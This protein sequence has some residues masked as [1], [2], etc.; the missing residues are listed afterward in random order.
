MILALLFNLFIAELVQT[1]YVSKLCAI[2]TPYIIFDYII[3]SKGHQNRSILTADVRLVAFFLFFGA[4]VALTFFGLL[5]AFV[6]P[7]RTRLGLRTGSTTGSGSTDLST[8]L[9]TMLITGD[10]PTIVS[11]Y[12]AFK[13]LA[14]AL[15]DLAK[16]HDFLKCIERK[17]RI[18]NVSQS[19]FVAKVLHRSLYL[20]CQDCCD[21]SRPLMCVL[22][23]T[24]SNL[25][26]S[27]STIKLSRWR[28]FQ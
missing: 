26:S 1:M 16:P 5:T 20:F 12:L 28:S 10:K 19:C 6:S 4:L 15:T 13:S 17:P 14:M 22:T 3:F 7:W 21:W 27:N 8:T 11:A 2:L 24:T 23:N 18:C 9:S 25:C